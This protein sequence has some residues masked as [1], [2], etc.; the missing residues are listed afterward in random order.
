MNG[1]RCLLLHGFTGGPYEVMPLAEHLRR[2]GYE[3]FVPELPGHDKELLGLGQV[4]WHDWLDAAAGEAHRL[5]RAGG[6]FDLVGFSMGGLISAYLANRFP[7]R[8]LVLLNAAAIYVSPRLF[9]KD[10][11]QRMRSG[12]R[13]QWNKMTRTP[14]PAAVQFLKLA[15]HVRREELPRVTVPTLVVQ[16][17]RDH[18]IHPRSAY[19]IYERLRGD[20]RLVWF[21][22]SGHMICHE[23]EAR[24]VFN[25]VEQFL[26][27]EAYIY[28]TDG[29]RLT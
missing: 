20:K 21:P 4:T 26:C 24:E 8:R 2:I 7:V 9:V 16:S 12:D 25:A 17:Q 28:K 14:L 29:E 18:I 23:S 11:L 1:E 15:R 22:Q 5:T 6:S 3:C 13:R 19:Y 27:D 10:A